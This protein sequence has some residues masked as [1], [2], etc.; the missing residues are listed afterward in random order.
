ML[1][2]AEPA[3][4]VLQVDLK[5]STGPCPAGQSWRWGGAQPSPSL[6]LPGTSR[7]PWPSAENWLLPSPPEATQKRPFPV[8]GG[9][10]PA[11]SGEQLGF[12]TCAFINTHAHETVKDEQLLLQAPYRSDPAL[13]RKPFTVAQAPRR[14]EQH[15]PRGNDQASRQN[16]PRPLSTGQRPA[17]AAPAREAS[18]FPTTALLSSGAGEQSLCRSP[19]APPGGGKGCLSGGR[20]TRRALLQV[21]IA[22][23]PPPRETKAPPGPGGVCRSP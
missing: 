3:G 2:Q 13:D 20:T 14:T 11:Q 19:P 8:R 16:V 17:G 23:G 7:S 18:P 6:Q 4:P 1:I 21:G 12:S 9:G 15:L 5:P 10:V 22:L